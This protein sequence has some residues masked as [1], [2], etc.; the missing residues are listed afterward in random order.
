MIKKSNL[1]FGGLLLALM[2]LSLTGCSEDPVTTLAKANSELAEND[3]ISA[4]LHLLTYLE[5]KPDDGDAWLKLARSALF[6]GKGLDA[7]SALERAQKSGVSRSEIQDLYVE[8]LLLQE[9]TDR[10]V[11]EIARIP[12]SRSQR[13]SLLLGRAYA[14]D[15]DAENAL[16]SLAE[17]LAKHP[18][19]AD[20]LSETARV[21]LAQND[22]ARAETSARAAVSVGP[23]SHEAL[24]VNGDLA[25]VQGRPQIA[26]EHFG[27][28]L[29][30]WPVSIRTTPKPS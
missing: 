1:R 11:V 30:A 3:F 7:E 17:G 20:L 4:R 13:A 26:F 5:D 29:R 25:L 12:S 28:A 9:K 19:N 10:A 22:I 16:R 15:G 18:R 21:Y 14:I 27:T 8:A 2:P 24:L 6:L 23:T